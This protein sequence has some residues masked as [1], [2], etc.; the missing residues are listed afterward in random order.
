MPG[1]D[2]AKSRAAGFVCGDAMAKRNNILPDAAEKLQ[3]EPGYA[4]NGMSLYSRTARKARG[5]G[6]NAARNFRDHV[7]PNDMTRL[8]ALI[9]HELAEVRRLER[10]L[11]RGRPDAQDKLT[12]TQT[13]LA[14]LLAEQRGIMP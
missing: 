10:A 14:R 7:S 3:I 1:R 8:E 9:Q 6:G 11:E 13:L 5:G 12:K 4:S 2:A